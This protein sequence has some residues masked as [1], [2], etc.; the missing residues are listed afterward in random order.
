MSHIRLRDSQ[1]YSAL[2][3]PKRK[4]DKEN[5]VLNRF[6]TVSILRIACIINNE[7]WRNAFAM[8]IQFEPAAAIRSVGPSVR[9]S[10]CPFAHLDIR[11]SVLM[12]LSSKSY[13]LEVQKI[14]KLSKTVFRISM[15]SK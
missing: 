1:F 11:P 6:V 2:L 7:F 10:I 14:S 9:P 13:Q 5:E 15:V 12:I 3:E 8:E 4:K